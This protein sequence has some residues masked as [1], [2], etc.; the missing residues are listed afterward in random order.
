MAVDLEIWANRPDPNSR[1][2][3]SYDDY[4]TY[5]TQ[6]YNQLLTTL[7]VEIVPRV[8]EFL[9]IM[10]ESKQVLKVEW[11]LSG[12]SFVSCRITIE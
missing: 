8:G 2:D 6:R 7:S 5:G 12:N 10:G 4:M 11:I 1:A 9:M 3:D